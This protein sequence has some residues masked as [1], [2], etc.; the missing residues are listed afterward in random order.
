[1]Q[2]LIFA[3]DCNVSGA[4]NANQFRL[5]FEL[6]NDDKDSNVVHKGPSVFSRGAATQNP[7]Q[8]TSTLTAYLTPNTRLST[9]RLK[10][11]LPKINTPVSW[12]ALQSFWTAAASLYKAL[13][14]LTLTG[15]V[16][17]HTHCRLATC[18]LANSTFTLKMKHCH[19]RKQKVLFARS[20][21]GQPLLLC[22]THDWTLS[23]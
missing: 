5:V 23:T 6:P 2:K 14:P 19:K 12:A 18:A 3:F 15:Y 8:M 10:Y 17:T 9:P 11:C 13:L 1:M 16:D 22:V 4:W 20:F 21:A 7:T